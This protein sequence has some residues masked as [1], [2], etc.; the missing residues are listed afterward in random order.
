MTP[1][2]AEDGNEGKAG[3]REDVHWAPAMDEAF[4]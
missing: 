4:C 3:R 2:Q 1:P